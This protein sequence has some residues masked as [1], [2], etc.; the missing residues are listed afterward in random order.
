ML[1]QAAR[2]FVAFLVA[3]LLVIGVLQPDDVVSAVQDW[4]SGGASL[5]V[6]DS[7]GL[8]VGVDDCVPHAESHEDVR[9]HVLRVTGVGSDL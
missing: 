4:P 3:T 8:E 2:R 1:W 9:A 5:V 6:Y 7:H